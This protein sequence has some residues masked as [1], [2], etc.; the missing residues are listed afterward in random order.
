MA[1]IKV[2][3][4]DL[5]ATSASLKSAAE[6][7][8]NTSEQAK[9]QVEGLVQGDWTGTASSAFD[10]AF[11]QWKSGADQVDQALN[12]IG[13]LLNNAAQSYETTEQNIT[14]SFG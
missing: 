14:S 12:R 7:I 5:H 1:I 11:M 13:E 8:K 2:T 6:T 3:S 4:E 10:Q 9:S